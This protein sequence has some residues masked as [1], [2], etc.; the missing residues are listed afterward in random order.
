MSGPIALLY[1]AIVRNDDEAKVVAASSYDSHQ[2]G[3]HSLKIIEDYVRQELGKDGEA[4][5]FEVAA[6]SAYVTVEQVDLASMGG[7]KWAVVVCATRAYTENNAINCGQVGLVTQ[8]SF[9]VMILGRRMIFARTQLMVAGVVIRAGDSD[10]TG[11]KYRVSTRLGGV[12]AEK[13]RRIIAWL[14][15]KIWKVDGQ[16]QKQMGYANCILQYARIALA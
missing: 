12:G 1:V 5:R 8:P 2:L 10:G 7:R 9:A 13:E 16:H 11:R 3:K 14:E 15:Q 4:R 6:L